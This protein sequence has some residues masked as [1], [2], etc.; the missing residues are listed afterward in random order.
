[1]PARLS[2][3]PTRFSG[4]SP[5]SARALLAALALLVAAGIL[6]GSTT[7]RPVPAPAAPP[8]A[9]GN[10]LAAEGDAALYQ[11]IA[12]R[13]AT[14]DGYYAAAVTGPGTTRCAPS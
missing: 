5:G 11:A 2:P 9:S 10:P 14:G 6:T 1:M 4:W 12:A 3:T 8:A 7:P 13:I